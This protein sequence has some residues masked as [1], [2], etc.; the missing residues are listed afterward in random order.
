[1][2]QFN[3]HY[4]DFY[5]LLFFC[6]SFIGWL[7]EV[8]LYLIRSGGLVN[9][10]VYYGPYLPVYG[11]GGLLLM[12]FFHTK[13][14]HPVLVFTCSAF[15]CT[16]VEYVTAVWLEYK[17]G[18]RWWD[19]SGAFGN[20]DGKI[21]LLCSVG[22]GIGG[23]LLICVFQPFFLKFYHRTTRGMCIFLSITLILLFVADAA[24]SIIRPNTGT[25][26]TCIFFPGIIP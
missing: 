12:I 3:I 15:L 22:F 14:K 6:L 10:G 7:W 13:R 4:F 11:I 21:C 9:R 17:W 26:I 23:V 16:V 18:V 20:I 8:L 25:N 24:Y 2:K 19:Y 1:M 5:V